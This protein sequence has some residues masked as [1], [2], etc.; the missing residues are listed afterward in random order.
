[1]SFV[2]WLRRFFGAPDPKQGI[3]PTS[4]RGGAR[5]GA[6]R[7]PKGCPLRADHPLVRMLEE[8][9]RDRVSKQFKWPTVDLVSAT[10]KR[11]YNP[12]SV[13]PLLSQLIKLRVVRRVGKG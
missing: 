2:A 8:H 10:M 6:G 13:S 4:R 3:A 11:G 1:M 5:P 12:D 7:K 9:V